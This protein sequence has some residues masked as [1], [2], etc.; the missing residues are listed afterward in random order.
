MP[1][2]IGLRGVARAHAGRVVCLVAADAPTLAPPL[3][4]RAEHAADLVLEVRAFP[5]ACGRAFGY[6]FA[7][8][9]RGRG[10]GWGW[11]GVV[12]GAAH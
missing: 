12:W 6:A 5:R 1:L 7:Y 10:M 9:G 4:A 8:A 2:L 11:G 3:R